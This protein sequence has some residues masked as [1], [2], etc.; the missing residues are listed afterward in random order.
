MCHDLVILLP[1]SISC[2]LSYLKPNMSDIIELDSEL[3][4]S[5]EGW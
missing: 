4:V 2:I 3:L 5:E 1:K